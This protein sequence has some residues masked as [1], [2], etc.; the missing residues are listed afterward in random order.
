MKSRS[1]ISTHYTEGANQ[2]PDFPSSGRLVSSR[3]A[4]GSAAPSVQPRRVGQRV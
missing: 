3:P 2:I 4:R 1:Y